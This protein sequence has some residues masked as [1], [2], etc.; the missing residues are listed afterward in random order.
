MPSQLYWQSV[1]LSTFLITSIAS[2]LAFG[3]ANGGCDRDTPPFSTSAAGSATAR[4]A[5]LASVAAVLGVDAQELEST[6][7]PPPPAGDLESDIHAFTTIEACVESR[8]QMDPLLGDAL[9]AIGY[10]TFLNDACRVLDAAKA[11]DARR[12]GAIDASVL[13]ERCTATVAEIA[14]EA[15]TCPWEIAGRPAEGRDPACL[16]IASRDRRLCAGVNGGSPRATCEAIAAHDASVCGRLPG[17]AAQARCLRTARR[18]MTTVAA[19]HDASRPLV[20]GGILTF[21]AASAAGA[22]A[23]G[24]MVD[25][26]PDLE[27]GVVLVQRRDGLRFTAGYPRVGVEAIGASP[28]VRAS[29]ALDLFVPSSDSG[30]S[31]AIERAVLLIPGRV[32]IVTPSARSTLQAKFETF[33]PARAGTLKLVVDGDLTDAASS[34]HVHAEVTTFVR[35]VVRAAEILRSESDSNGREE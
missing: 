34:W 32:P 30:T 13:R 25:F 2:S 4:E 5:P 12:C 6:A 27:R 3:C 35:D 33:E 22:E 19:S 31:G 24:T 9:D 21:S 26:G 20:S 18:W 23:S 16:A 10:E 11:R 28:N 8:S 29:I 1:Q 7:G 14:G 17:R 15:D